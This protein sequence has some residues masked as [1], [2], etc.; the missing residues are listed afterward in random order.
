MLLTSTVLLFMMVGTS[1]AL[2]NPV[3]VHDNIT[4]RG[5]D[6]AAIT[7]PADCTPTTAFSAKETCGA[8]H[9]GSAQAAC[10]KVLLS[11]DEIE[12]HAYHAQL[13]ANQITGW[14]SHPAKAWMQSV[15]HFG[16]W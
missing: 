6:G 9:N 4:L 14:Q 3:Y 13:G 5:P 8:C 1:L 2:T 15:A 10:G 11:Y 7:T 12:K 16:N